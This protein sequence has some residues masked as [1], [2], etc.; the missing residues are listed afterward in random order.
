MGITLVN[1]NA[2]GTTWDVTA[3][4]TTYT[5]TLGGTQTAGNLVVVWARNTSTNRS[6]AS[7]TDSIGGNT[8][9]G[10]GG[11]YSA[12]WGSAS[13]QVGHSVLAVGGA[14]M[15]VTVTISGGNTGGANAGCAEFSSTTGWPASP[16]DSVLGNGGTTEATWTSGSITTTQ[17]E[18][19]IIAFSHDGSS[20]RTVTKDTGYSD[21]VIPS[22]TS[23]IFHDE[24]KVTSSTFSGTVAFTPNTTVAAWGMVAASFKNN[25]ATA[26]RRVIMVS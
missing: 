7:A 16:L 19:V 6:W 9:S 26:N 23:G 2:S 8:W 17:A 22:T 15:V 14:G 18:D 11:D 12:N 3:T 5:C 4:A 13:M 10:A 24:Y 25:P 21:I 20:N 1:K